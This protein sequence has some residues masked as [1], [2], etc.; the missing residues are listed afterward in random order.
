MTYKIIK[1][2]FESLR[3]A[4]KFLGSLYNKYDHARCISWPPS[5]ENGSYMFEVSNNPHPSLIPS[6]HTLTE[7]RENK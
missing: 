2:Q 5:G 4:S 6:V 3:S 1:R 7:I